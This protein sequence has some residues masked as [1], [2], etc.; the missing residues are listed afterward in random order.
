VVVGLAALAVVLSWPAG[1]LAACLTMDQV[2]EISGGGH[3]KELIWSGTHYSSTCACPGATSGISGGAYACSLGERCRC[4]TVD[5]KP[6]LGTVVHRPDQQVHDFGS[7][8]KPFLRTDHFFLFFM[9]VNLLKNRIGCISERSDG[10]ASY[11]CH[12]APDVTITLSGG[13]ARSLRSVTLYWKEELPE[14]V[15][16][17]FADLY[18]GQERELLHKE[19]GRT[20][21][22]PTRGC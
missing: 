3:P 17:R 7:T 18:G 2:Y 21:R 8:P 12:V 9:E 6:W 11:V 1:T 16:N 10:E 14:A 20:T 4:G 5:G 15:A 13:G 22:V 19:L